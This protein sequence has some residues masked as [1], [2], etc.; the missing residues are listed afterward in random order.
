MF[1]ETAHK[2]INSFFL[3][4]FCIAV[5][6]TKAQTKFIPFTHHNIRYEGRIAIQKDAAELSWSGQFCYN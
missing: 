4:L 1:F 5:T 2:F 6:T 3:L